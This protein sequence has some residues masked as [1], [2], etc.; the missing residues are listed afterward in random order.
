[1]SKSQ[2]AHLHVHTEY[3]LL[4]GIASIESLVKATREHG[5]P[6]LA[7]TDHGN[8]HGAIDFYSCCKEHGVKPIIGCELYVAH[9][10]I[11]S[12]TTQ[13]R[14]P[15]HLTVLAADNAGY[16]NLIAL[17]TKGHHEG[18]Y[19]K[20]RVD[21]S[22]LQQHSKGLIVLSGCPSAELPSL[23]RDTDA[24][25]R[26]ALD[27]CDWYRQTFGERYFLEIQRHGNLEFLPGLNR[28]LVQL[29]KSN[30]IPLVATND[31]HYTLPGESKS[32]D[33]YLAIQT[34]KNLDDADRLSFSDASYYL[35]SP[36][37]MS[38]LFHDL[39]AAIAATAE[40]AQ[41]CHVDLDFGQ[42]AMPKYP[43]PGDIGA[44]EYLAQ[45]CAAGF[46]EHRLP[47]D[48]VYRQRLNYELAVIRET[49]FADYFLVV[50]DV[51]RHTRE[52][53][54]LLG[55]RGSA[56]ASLVLYCLNITAADPIE[57]GLVFERFLNNERKELPDI[58]LDLQ[59]DRREEAMNYVI[60][61]YGSDR[62]AQIV[63]FARYGPK[64]AIKAAAR[65]SGVSYAESNDLAAMIPPKTGNL[66]QA[67]KTVPEL[68]EMAQ[69]RPEIEALLQ[70]ADG[71]QQVV[72]QTSSHAAG[73]VVSAE[74][75][76]TIVPLQQ[77][78]VKGDGLSVTQFDMDAVS[79]I[80]L[81]KMDFLGLTSF[82]I[83]DQVMRAAP[84]APQSLEEIPLDDP[85]TYRLLGSGNTGN[86][87]QLE[88][89]GMQRY[90]A[91]LKPQHLSDISAMIALYRPGPIE[92]IDRFIKSRHGHVKIS[93]PHES[94]KETL[95]ETYGVIVYQ[96]QV[97]RIMRDFAGYSLGQA[98][99]VRKA[100]GK[101]IP[102]LMIEERSNFIQGSVDNGY[103][104][105]DAEAIFDLIEPFAGYA[106]NKAHSIS[107]ALLSYWTAW[108]K[109]HYSKH[110]MAAALKSRQDQ[111]KTLYRTALR[112]CKRM[113]ISLL[114]PCFNRSDASSV[115][116]G[117][118]AIRFGL[119]A[120]SS[121]GVNSVAQLLDE[122]R[123]NGPYESLD[124]LAKRF[125]PQRMS[126]KQFDA[127]AQAGALDALV[128]RGYAVEKSQDIWQYVNQVSGHH[129]TGQASLFAVNSDAM[130]PPEW[131]KPPASHEAATPKQKAEW[132]IAQLGAPLSWNPT[133]MTTTELTTIEEISQR[134]AGKQITVAGVFAEVNHRVTREE[135][136]PYVLAVLNLDD[137]AVEVMIWENV[138]KQVPENLCRAYATVSVTGILRSRDDGYTISADVVSEIGE[139]QPETSDVAFNIPSTRN[140]KGDHRRLMQC[141]YVVTHYPGDDPLRFRIRE[142]GGKATTVEMPSVTIESD[143]PDLIARLDAILA[144]VAVA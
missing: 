68:S 95:D 45:L 116:E 103:S 96:D 94:L 17:V 111:N 53:G 34:G 52:Q 7:I 22:L 5:A 27:A 135:K 130:P 25:S 63:T 43:T 136:R 8:L 67:A 106:F 87:F 50:W 112:E 21:R 91:E 128:E 102:K 129:D 105:A 66:S 132:E 2:F 47:D 125:R 61:T 29:S 49:R 39:P 59:D 118:N 48:D 65:V 144:P 9:Q 83:L 46:K 71:I 30:G 139:P 121:V 119:T 110:Y 133:G 3:S 16:S 13:E 51:V 72:H 85:D 74:P 115:P 32:H 92:H 80:G 35:K 19:Q 33:I 90:I 142:S 60:S 88:S 108:F 124:N 12:R 97:L 126:G 31:S 120:V 138:L 73:I 109:T 44:D 14:S 38:E 81:L 55:V 23:L 86:V 6:A 15:H 141:L 134:R 122:R 78:T 24:P 77:P 75:L 41:S 100:M 56:A 99:I 28:N 131:L 69:R 113:G 1:M 54:I 114:P 104:R 57:H 117:E 18:F 58:D 140:P 40:I 36:A 26:A 143:H 20:P 107:Y 10:S 64:S 93:Y 98:D 101:K 42:K 127:L 62:V 89:A 79:K 82:A 4:D 11:D 76:A 70:N 137:G 84:G 37:E 123:E